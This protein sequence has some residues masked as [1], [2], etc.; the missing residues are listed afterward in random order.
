[1]VESIRWRRLRWRLRGAWLWPAFALATAV[2]AVLAVRMPFQGEGADAFGAVLF[3]GFV[4]LLAVALIAPL[5]GFLLRRRRR[6]LPWFI[7]RDYAGTGLLVCM[8]ALLFAGG[9][10]HH[11]ALAAKRDERHAVFNAVHAYVVADAPQFIPGLNAIY[12]RELEPHSYRAC[13]YRP[14]ERLPICFFV[15]TDQTPAGIKRDP[16]RHGNAP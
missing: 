12:L 16:D 15:N 14:E 8:T 3:A 13:V 1:M 2:D 4:N 5:A 10:A 6:D 9:L 7:A 11:S